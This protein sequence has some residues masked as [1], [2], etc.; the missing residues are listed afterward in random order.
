MKL[1]RAL[2]ISLSLF[3]VAA[4][5]FAQWQTP[6]H[7][8]PIGRGTGATGFKSTAPGAAGNVLT[9][10]G[11][12]ADPSFQTPVLN[13]AC[14]LLPTACTSLFGY[15]NV[16]WYGA[17][18]DG[19]NVTATVSITSGA[20][21]LTAAGATFI[22]A[23]V[24]K[25]IVVPGAGA[26]GAE[27]ITTIA[28]VT[29]ATHIRLVANAAT[30]LSAVSKSVFYGTNNTSAI[31]AALAA[32]KAVL[33]PGGNFGFSGTLRV[34]QAGSYI[35]GLGTEA[36]F[37]TSA[38]KSLPAIQVFGALQDWGVKHLSLTRAPVAVVG[39]VGVLQTETMDAGYLDD[40]RVSKHYIGLSL[41]AT[42]YSR[43]THSTLIYNVSHGV[44]FTPDALFGTS[45][46]QWALD[47]VISQQNGGDGFR[48]DNTLAPLGGGSAVGDWIHLST[49]GNGGSAFSAHGL[50][51]RPINNLRILKMFVGGDGGTTSPEIYLDT[52]NDNSHPHNFTDCQFELGVEGFTITGN[53]GSVSITN[54][55]I[56]AMTLNGINNQGTAKLTVTGGFIINNGLGIATGGPLQM[57]NTTLSN[58]N[59]AA[60]QTYGIAFASGSGPHLVQGNNFSFIAPN[61]SGAIFGVAAVAAGSKIVNNI[62]YNPVGGHAITVGASP[63]TYTAGPSGEDVFITGGTVSGVNI[64][65]TAAYGAVT[66]VAVP[67]GPGQA[68]TLSYTAAPT[69]NGVQR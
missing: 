67:L 42:G 37:L 51:S 17:L 66:N 25:T 27:L 36:T 16:A 31:N 35:L 68:M 64:G 32:A 50:P 69:M 47:D 57:V 13:A 54:P 6:D 8:V 38:S 7:S 65:S 39:G 61:S 21:F 18:G 56:E 43:L 33:V 9:S 4:P 30:T 58:A 20:A 10:N 3:L 49:Y 22:T 19:I 2:V 26:A 44:E 15:T 11:P 34:A 63:F 28:T 5:A 1:F 41:S 12:A 60:T 40:I 48:I 29:D 62:G 14:I 24:G 53:N 59:G 52:Y 55:W 46:Y 23:D 45:G